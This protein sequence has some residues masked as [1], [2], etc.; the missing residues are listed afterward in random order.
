MRRASSLML[1]AALCGIV[2]CASAACSRAPTPPSAV[3]LMGLRL[4]FGL[5]AQDVR[6][7]DP[8]VVSFSWTNETDRK[9][10][11]E[12]WRGPT[13]GV[14]ELS[15]GG[16]RDFE[17]RFAGTRLEY[18]GGFGCG[19]RKEIILDPGATVTREYDVSHCYSFGAVGVYELRTL[20]SSTPPES[21]MD[22]R[23]T[24]VPWRGTLTPTPLL[25]QVRAKR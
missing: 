5:K 13:S 20:Y 10:V 19:P 24:A 16:T 6:I 18:H 8:V 12:D 3:T 17:V 1:G 7:G 21:A 4:T 25:L 2:V 11:I 9:L 15:D 22:R 14:S 23:D